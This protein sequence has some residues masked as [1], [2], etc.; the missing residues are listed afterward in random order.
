MFTRP[1]CIQ[2]LV[3]TVSRVSANTQAVFLGFICFGATTV[4]PIA[5]GSRVTMCSRRVFVFIV[6]RGAEWNS[7]AKRT[8]ITSVKKNLNSGPE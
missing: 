8:S 5:L 6:E 3:G 7:G 2:L 4:F 1:D